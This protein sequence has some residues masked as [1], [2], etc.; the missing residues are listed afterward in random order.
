MVAPRAP[1]SVLARALLSLGL[2]T[3]A[4]TP[5]TA[6]RLS[7]LLPTVVHVQAPAGACAPPPDA[8]DWYASMWVENRRSHG[9]SVCTTSVDEGHLQQVATVGA[10]TTQAFENFPISYYP[11]VFVMERPH[12]EGMALGSF[13]PSGRGTASTLLL[14]RRRPPTSR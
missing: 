7:S 4:A 13:S 10:D 6:W 1:R 12:C 9:L 5:A 8:A 14:R 3:A 11:C 2:V